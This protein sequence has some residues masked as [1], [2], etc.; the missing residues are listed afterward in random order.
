MLCLTQLKSQK[1]V[2]SYI[3]FI[4]LY[5][6][7]FF[8]FSRTTLILCVSARDLTNLSN[9]NNYSGFW[10][11]SDGFYD[12]I[13]LVGMSMNKLF[14]IKISC[15]SMLSRENSMIEIWVGVY[16]HWLPSI[17]VF[18]KSFQGKEQRIFPESCDSFLY[19]TRKEFLSLILNFLKFLPNFLWLQLQKMNHYHVALF[20]RKL[21]S[22]FNLWPNISTI[23]WRNPWKKILIE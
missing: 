21:W 12:W 2:G 15:V 6:H 14:C 9:V 11:I 13:I 10:Q 3:W 23:S 5:F 22:R 1:C 18:S 16:Q 8:F 20:S 4:G 17:F 19:V 7:S